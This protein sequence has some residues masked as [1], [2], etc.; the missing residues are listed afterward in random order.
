[1]QRRKFSREFKLEAVKLVTERGVSVAQAHQHP[2]GLT[3]RQLDRQAELKYCPRTFY[4]DKQR[5]EIWDQW[6]WGE[7]L[8]SIGRGFDRAPSSIFSHLT[9]M[10]R[11]RP[12]EHIRFWLQGDASSGH[13]S[14][15]HD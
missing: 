1:M 6:Q 3:K 13:P 12:T 15:A 2:G 9:R 8:S 7:S 10:G 5:S 11:I 4:S 14:R